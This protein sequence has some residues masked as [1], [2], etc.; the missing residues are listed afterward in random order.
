MHAE[1]SSCVQVE[2]LQRKFT[3]IHSTL[4]Q[5]QT[6]K[7][8]EAPPSPL[9]SSIPSALASVEGALPKARPLWNPSPWLG[10]ILHPALCSWCSANR[11]P[12]CAGCQPLPRW[13][14]VHVEL[15][16]WVRLPWV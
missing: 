10:L 4:A 1:H 6:A 15:G 9:R 5:Q 2:R 12:Y 16:L 3:S 13:T 11:K 8:P 7:A 14:D